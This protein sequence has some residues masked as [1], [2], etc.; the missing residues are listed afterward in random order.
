[1]I[2]YL[3]SSSLLKLYLQ[4]YGSSAVRALV[5]RADHVYTSCVAY[6]EGRS[7]LARARRLARLAAASYRVA[8]D[9]FEEGWTAVSVV[10]V[11]EP[12]FRHAGDLA[13]QH[14]LRGLDALH[15]ASALAVQ[16][17]GGE[18]VTFSAWDDRLLAA[19]AAEGLAAAPTA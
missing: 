10:G 11:P 1:M 9:Q 18:P 6:V 4:E 17:D 14:G 5:A 15:L 7:G 16:R 2:L 8:L 12:L 19:A 3:D 13:E